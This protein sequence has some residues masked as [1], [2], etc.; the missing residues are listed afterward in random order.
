MGEGIFLRALPFITNFCVVLYCTVF[1]PS[2]GLIRRTRADSEARP[3]AP[4]SYSQY[5][6]MGRLTKQKNAGTWSPQ[7]YDSS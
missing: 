6:V 1:P 2:T 7:R 3:D 5:D 4:E